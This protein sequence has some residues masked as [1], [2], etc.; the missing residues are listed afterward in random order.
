MLH[1]WLFL[2][3]ACW[4][5]RSKGCELSQGRSGGIIFFS[6]VNFLLLTL[7]WH[8]FHPTLLQW[9]A[10]HSSDSAKTA[11]GK[12]H[13]HTH[14]PLTHQSRSGLT[15]LSGHSG[16]EPTIKENELAHNSSGNTQLQ[17]SQLTKQLW[18]NPGLKSGIGA[19]QV[20]S[21]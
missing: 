14:T 3:I 13:I 19:C 9:H 18:T 17:S 4:Q 11:G 15:M 20:I 10:K 2:G 6:K 12:L 1:S 5:S 7:I 21:A 8:P 16:G